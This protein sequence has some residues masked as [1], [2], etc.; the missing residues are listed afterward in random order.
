[1]QLSAADA[2][3]KR[4]NV[5]EPLISFIL[6]FYK[7]H[8]RWCAQDSN[9]GLKE[10]NQLTRPLQINKDRSLDTQDSNL[11]LWEINEPT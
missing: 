6:F 10:I 2:R 3:G 1:M 4:S 11:G 8:R 7:S 5:N 9:I